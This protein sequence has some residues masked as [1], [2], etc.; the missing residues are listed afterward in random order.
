MPSTASAAVQRTPIHLAQLIHGQ[1]PK[2]QSLGMSGPYVTMLCDAGKLDAIETTE[3][4][5][6]R[7][8][9]EAVEL[10]KSQ[11]LTRYNDAPSMRKADVEAHLYN[12]DDSFD[13]NVVRDRAAAQRRAK[14]SKSPRK[15]A[16]P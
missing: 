15:K 16:R 8:Q 13:A 6:R 5:H 10:Y 11:S 1:L 3:G 2:R 14:E 7:I 9:R 4:G 12:H